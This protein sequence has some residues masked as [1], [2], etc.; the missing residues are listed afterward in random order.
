MHPITE[1]APATERRRV[2]VLFVNT[3]IALLGG[4][5]STLLGAFA[6]RPPHE[7]SAHEWV[8]AGGMLE[9]TPDTP[10]ARV[11]SVPRVDGWY[12]ERARHTV[13]LIW[14]GGQAVHAMSAT[15]THLGCQVRWQSEQKTFL[16]PC[17]G[18]AYDAA[19]NVLSGPPPRRLDRL[20]TRLDP[21][22]TV[23]VRL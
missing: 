8:R 17:H 14:D 21:D 7:E 13:F 1:P 6:A 5:L 3:T 22:G 2:L 20:E 15:C 10:V 4:A 19:G 18:G 11:L 16:C 9:L 23:L 12:R